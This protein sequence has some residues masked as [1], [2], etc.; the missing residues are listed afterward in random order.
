LGS[1]RDIAAASAAAR[2]LGRFAAVGSAAAV[3]LG[4]L[5]CG[6]RMTWE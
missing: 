2:A 5:R 6:R 1:E 4:A 3:V